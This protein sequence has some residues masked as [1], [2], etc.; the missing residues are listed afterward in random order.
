MSLPPSSASTTTATATSAW[1]ASLWPLRRTHR[2]SA[3]W[4]AGLLILLGS[5]TGRWGYS[6]RAAAV[7]TAKQQAGH[8]DISCTKSWLALNGGRF[9]FWGDGVVNG[10]A[11]QGTSRVVHGC[12]AMFNVND[13]HVDRRELRE[14][15]DCGVSVLYGCELTL[16]SLAPFST[17][18]LSCAPPAL[19][20]V[21]ISVTSRMWCCI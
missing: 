2:R 7:V 16:C 14:W 21:W 3:R 5:S 18:R 10:V 15:G 12:S 13:R 1:Q 17:A 8:G 9:R 4:A 19:I 20:A 11:T 6:K